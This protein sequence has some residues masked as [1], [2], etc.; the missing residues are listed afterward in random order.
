MDLTWI[1]PS[2]AGYLFDVNRAVVTGDGVGGSTGQFERV[3]AVVQVGPGGVLRYHDSDVEMGSRYVYRLE[4]SDDSELSHTTGEIY[5]RVTRGSLT[6]NY[7]NPFN[8]ATRITYYVPDGGVQ[9]V[10]LIVYDVS[11]ARVKTLFEG[12]RRGGKYTVEWDGRNSVGEPVSSGVYF[13]RLVEGD[14]TATKKM[15]LIK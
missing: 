12:M 14:F 5:I 8:P 3:A 9:R 4:A 10:S 2:W 7:P 1:L 6:Q 11:G 15:L 13:Y